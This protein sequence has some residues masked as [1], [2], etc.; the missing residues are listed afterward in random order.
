MVA[1]RHARY[2]TTLA[3]EE[4]TRIL[5]GEAEEAT[6]A[7]IA[8]ID[9]VRAA[10][11]WLLAHGEVDAAAGLGI[12]LSGFWERQGWLHDGRDLVTRCLAQEPAIGDAVTH[13][14]LLAVA[15]WFAHLQADYRAAD[16][17]QRRSLS[18]CREAGDPEGEANALNNLAI[19]A[20]AQGRIAEA[21]EAFEASLKLAGALGDI[22]KQ[23]ARWSN[24]GMLATQEGELA[25]AH[26]HLQ[27]AHALFL[28]AGDSH[29]AAACLCNQSDLAL[30]RGE[31]EEAEFLSRESLRLFR[32]LNDVQGTAYA[33]ANLA[34]AATGCGEHEAALENVLEALA[35]CLKIGM[36]WL[37]PA[38][39]EIY[40][41]NQAARGSAREALF[42]LTAASNFR[43][44]MHA[45]RSSQQQDA[46]EHLE[47]SLSALLGE[48]SVRTLRLRAATLPL[49]TVVSEALATAQESA[50][51]VL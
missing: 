16:D 29:G 46:M 4:G 38:L 9:N 27:M 42:H 50:R 14:R 32:E 48:T 23:A 20:Q 6:G 7:L 15:G 22:R 49:E 18:L 17:Y 45:P 12:A 25:E 21:R 19:T 35:I 28:R 24:L 43:E 44:Q 41:R 34:E 36:H 33:M 40:A 11:E 31:W 13:A 3:Q 8:D 37:A 10:L 30:Q 1:E 47:A 2:Y 39:L 26:E 51:C 5:E